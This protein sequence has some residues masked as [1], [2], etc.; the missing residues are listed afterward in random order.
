[1][2]E[3]H[4]DIDWSEVLTFYDLLLRAWDTPLV[5]LNRAVVV[6]QTG[7]LETALAEVD[8]LTPVLADYRYLHATRADLLT[9]LGRTDDAINAYRAALACGGSE[10]ERDLLTSRAEALQ[11]NGYDLPP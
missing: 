1:M 11:R 7:D 5:R 3:R 9:H 6:A 2:P 10:P 8:A 4:E